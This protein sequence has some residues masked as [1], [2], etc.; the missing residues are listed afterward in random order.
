LWQRRHDRE[1]IPGVER[2]RLGHHPHIALETVK[3]GVHILKPLPHQLFNRWGRVEK[4]FEGGFYDH[5]LTDARTVGCNL[6][7]V[8]K[9]FGKSDGHLSG[10]G[11]TTL[12]R[13]RHGRLD[14]ASLQIEFAVE[15]H[16]SLFSLL[17]THQ[18]K[19]RQFQSNGFRQETI[20]PDGNDRKSSVASASTDR[21]RR[22]RSGVVKE[23]NGGLIR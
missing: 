10:R 6:K 11:R 23:R 2:D 22:S 17:Q 3:P 8:V 15:L 19:P 4:T 1:V 21:R 16:V 7:P 13:R 5:A 14:A 20:E 12:A 18:S 9:F